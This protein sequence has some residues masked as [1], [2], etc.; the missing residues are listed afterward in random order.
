MKDFELISLALDEIRKS[1]YR[2]SDCRSEASDRARR[3]A[4]GEPREIMQGIADSH[5]MA[6]EKCFQILKRLLDDML[7]H[8]NARQSVTAMDVALSEVSL[9]V[10]Y[11]RKSEKDFYE[12]EDEQ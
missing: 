4:P 1:A 9:D 5:G 8:E 6:M 10:I 12:K 3:M 2:M 11:G 7:E